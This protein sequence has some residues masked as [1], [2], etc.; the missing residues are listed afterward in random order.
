MRLTALNRFFRGI[1]QM[2][3]TYS[4]ITLLT[5][6]FALTA[7]A[8]TI[9]RY[10]GIVKSI[11]ETTLKADPKSQAWAHSARTILA[12]AE[13]SIAETIFSLQSI[14]NK[15]NRPLF[16]LPQGQAIDTALV[17]Q[18]LA[19][20]IQQLT[21]ADEN[22]NLSDVVVTNIMSKYPCQE[23]AHHLSAQESLLAPKEYKMVHVE[24]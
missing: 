5:L 10:A 11:P 3:W 8:D 13:E 16:C 23:A 17:H 24:S 20:I 15:M 19:Q 9:G 2:K 6:C 4:L 14:T 1:K 22:K 7:N 21:P 18:L 12:V